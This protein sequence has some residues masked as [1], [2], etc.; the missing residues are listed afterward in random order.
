MRSINVAGGFRW[1]TI[2]GGDLATW[3]LMHQMNVR[4]AATASMAALTHLKKAE[5]GCII[6]I[7][8]G[9]PVKASQHG[10]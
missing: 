9:A 1:E 2:E 3:D 7:A 4:T 8:A 10:A 6:N 5:A